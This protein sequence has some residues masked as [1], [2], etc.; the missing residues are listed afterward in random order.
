MIANVVIHCSDVP[1]PF[2]SGGASVLPVFSSSKETS[3]IVVEKKNEITSPVRITKENSRSMHV[4]DMSDARSIKTSELTTSGKLTDLAAL[5]TS[6]E[7]LQSANDAGKTVRAELSSNPV[8]I[9]HN[10]CLNNR[11]MVGAVSSSIFW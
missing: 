10:A 1:L 5:A 3:S 7:S 4:Y 2:S 9:I 8:R 6:G 11:A